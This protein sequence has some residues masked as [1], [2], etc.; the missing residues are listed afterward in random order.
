MHGWIVS[1]LKRME[2][3]REQNRDHCHKYAHAHM[4]RDTDTLTHRHTDIPTPI[5][6]HAEA[7]RHRGTETQTQRKERK[8]APIAQV[9][10]PFFPFSSLCFSPCRNC[11]AR[12]SYNC[13]AK[14]TN[15]SYDPNVHS[16][17]LGMGYLRRLDHTCDSL[18]RSSPLLCLLETNLLIFETPLD[19]S[20]RAFSRLHDCNR[21][22]RTHWR[23]KPY[24][25]PECHRNFVR[26]DA[27]TRH[28][29]LDFGHNRCSGYP[30]PVSGSGK[31]DSPSGSGTESTPVS[32]VSI[33]KA[34]IAIAP[35]PTSPTSPLDGASGL[36]TS[37]KSMDDPSGRPFNG[38]RDNDQTSPVDPIASGPSPMFANRGAPYERAPVSP[39]S[40]KEIILGHPPHNR[41]YSHSGHTRPL[42]SPTS[43]TKPSVPLTPTSATF[44]S[45]GHLDPDR[46]RRGSG[47][48]RLSTIVWSGPSTEAYRQPPSYE[49]PRPHG[50]PHG[51]PQ[52]SPDVRRSPPMHPSEW[53]QDRPD[54]N[55]AWNWEQQYERDARHR[56]P[57]WPSTPQGPPPGPGYRPPPARSSTLDSWQ[58]SHSYAYES[59]EEF[60]GRDPRE[61]DDARSRSKYPVSP[62]ALTH[63]KNAEVYTRPPLATLTRDNYQRSEAIN[64]RPVEDMEHPPSVA[65]DHRSRSFQGLETVPESRRRY[66]D[67]G[68][69]SPVHPRE[70]PRARDPPPTERSN[71]YGMVERSQPGWS[72]SRGPSSFSTKE[73]DPRAPRPGHGYEV[74]PRPSRHD[75]KIVIR[76]RRLSM[77]PEPSNRSPR[78]VDGS[79]FS[80]VEPQLREGAYPPH[81][82]IGPH[83]VE[84]GFREDRG[85]LAE[86]WNGGQPPHRYPHAQHSGQHHEDRYLPRRERMSVDMPSA[87]KRSLSI[88]TIPQ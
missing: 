22:M 27:L 13:T 30:G 15:R 5:H 28:L 54:P 64:D 77:S 84:S 53:P 3:G 49:E 18:A 80:F 14:T 72:H 48:P 82:L 61:R 32:P 73:F 65:W 78:A 9:F 62:V 16:F 35:A 39:S 88:A 81:R 8:K 86:E 21:H 87:P 25:C 83:D 44:G 75:S 19:D 56:N 63:E 26:Q 47:A 55:K 4:F 17:L 45:N 57:S 41:S 24:S 36:A 67:Y 59:R 76:E 60:V 12:F 66:D 69:L 51:P 46:D 29:R 42:Q 40:T 52:D 68:P 50:P 2:G 6:R 7:Q 74:P 79:R 23:I 1:L 58:R 31:D 20:A 85:H 71:S 70:S 38:P 43:T 37:P 34:P 10:A 33:K 11:T